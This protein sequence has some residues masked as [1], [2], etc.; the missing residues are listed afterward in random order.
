MVAMSADNESLWDRISRHDKEDLAQG[1]K[2]APAGKLKFRC[3]VCEKPMP[4]LLGNVSVFKLNRSGGLSTVACR[5]VTVHR[6]CFGEGEAWASRE[7]LLWKR[8]VKYDTVEEADASLREDAKELF[9]R[10]GHP[11]N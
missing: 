9:R 10:F 7:G 3:L 11:D 2:R 5:K 8:T 6:D 4:M 1:R